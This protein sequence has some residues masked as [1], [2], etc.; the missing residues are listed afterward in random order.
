MRKIGAPGLRPGA[1][2]A[3]SDLKA[4]CR[5]CGADLVGIADLALFKE[6]WQTLPPDLLEPF[7]RAVSVAVCLDH[8]IVDEIDRHPTVRYAEH[9]RAVN[10]DLD[11][12]A[13][14]AA[15]RI[16]ECGYRA[17]AVPASKIMDTE[18]L[19]GAISHKA[20][21]RMAGIGWQGKSLLI[22]SPEFGPR[23]RLATILTDMPLAPDRP[24][25]SRCGTCTKCTDACP[26]DAIKNATPGDRYTDRE[27]ALHFSRCA[28][29]TLDNSRM[30]GIG[31][32]ICGVCV[33]ACPHGKRKPVP[34]QG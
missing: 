31:A 8:G 20:I 9:Y 18:N 1:K 14:Q 5:A 17:A 11:R 4:F 26:V 29:R 25:K 6:G 16:T 2:D 13:A 7:I 19:L 10:E 27:E 32:R 24:I 12:I 22:V 34:A 15:G 21:A 30:P 3:A 23:I 28:G 33:K